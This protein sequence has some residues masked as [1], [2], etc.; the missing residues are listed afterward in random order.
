MD[1]EFIT[2]FQTIEDFVQKFFKNP[3][4][5]NWLGVFVPQIWDLR[6]FALQ[7]SF[8]INPKFLKILFPEDLPQLYENNLDEMLKASEIYNFVHQYLVHYQGIETFYLKHNEHVTLELGFQ[9]PFIRNS[10]F[11]KQTKKSFLNDPKYRYQ[12]TF[13]E[14][15]RGKIIITQENLSDESMVKYKIKMPEIIDWQ[16][17]FKVYLLRPP[18]LDKY[19]DLSIEKI[20]ISLP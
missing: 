4:I 5:A 17:Q 11:E 3:F 8:Q 1:K 2:S 13:R 7:N 6:E 9:L 19:W 18:V 20:F 12:N 10:R 16:K 14:N 15:L